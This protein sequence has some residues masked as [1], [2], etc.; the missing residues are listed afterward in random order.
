MK[1]FYPSCVPVSH[2]RTKRRNLAGSDA[3]SF[4][5]FPPFL[6]LPAPPEKEQGVQAVLRPG[7]PSF[8]HTDL[9]IEENL[10]VSSPPPQG[11]PG[12]HSSNG[13]KNAP[14]HRK[15]TTKSPAAMMARPD[16]NTRFRFRQN[17]A[18]RH[19][20]DLSSQGGI[21]V[22]DSQGF[23]PYSMCRISGRGQR[24]INLQC[25]CTT[26]PSPCKAPGGVKNFCVLEKP[27]RLPDQSK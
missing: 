20:S 18:I 6:K 13:A 21:T 7:R 25:Q 15:R 19:V 16:R 1:R 23:S 11:R 27:L 10:F 3:T 8:F 26:G 22:T 24:N 9:H 4:V 14:P 2:N 12:K 5:L 17:A